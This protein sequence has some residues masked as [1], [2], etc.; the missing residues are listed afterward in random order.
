MKRT[1]F[2]SLVIVGAFAL[3]AC[4]FPGTPLPGTSSPLNSPLAGVTKTAPQGKTALPRGG[5]VITMTG[6]LT[7][8]GKI[9][10]TNGVSTTVEVTPTTGAPAG[11]APQGNIPAV[12]TD[13]KSVTTHGT[14]NLRS[15]PGVN[16]RIVGFVTRNQTL[17]VTGA[18]TDGKWWRVDCNTP[19]TKVCWI[20]A[21]TRY[22]TA[23]K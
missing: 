20:I 8:T 16:Y 15:G 23:D 3:S 21:G 12:Q 22:V 2:I 13:V 10:T 18:S 17:Q 11:A 14:V 1:R 9:T 7:P 4:R 19:R 6:Q 5:D